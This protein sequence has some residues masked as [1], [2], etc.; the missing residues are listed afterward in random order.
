[1]KFRYLFLL[2]LWGLSACTTQTKFTTLKLDQSWTFNQDGKA[3]WYPATVPGV[4]HTDL[5]NNGLID[6]PYWGNNELST[7]WIENENW[8]YRTTF[9][10]E[11]SNLNA[12]NIEIQFD[13]L[14]TYAE[15]RLNGTLILSSNNMFRGW[16]VDIK[17][18]LKIGENI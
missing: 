13:G 8:N 14:D 3:E 10:V 17:P 6:D 18:H 7:Q 12:Q 2:F 1:M 9:T 11:S 5:L 4:V 15:V 16:N